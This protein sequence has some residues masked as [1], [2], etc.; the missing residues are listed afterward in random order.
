MDKKLARSRTPEYRK[1]AYGKILHRKGGKLVQ[2]FKK[3]TRMIRVSVE[4]ADKLT[5]KAAKEGKT[6][7]DYTQWLARRMR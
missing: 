6:L 2:G 5:A 3:V 1:K 4:Y 7:V